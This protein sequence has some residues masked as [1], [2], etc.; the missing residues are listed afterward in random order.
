[1]KTE[2]Y[3]LRFVFHFIC[4][5]IVTYVALGGMQEL[6][7]LIRETSIP[8]ICICNDKT[9][10]KMRSLVTNTFDLTFSRPKVEQIKSAI[11][12]ICFK[13]RI[14]IP[15]DS[16]NEIITGASQDMRQILNLLSMW[17]VNNKNLSSDSIARDSKLIKK[18]MKMVRC[19]NILF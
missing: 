16:F 10:M 19:K 3:E 7:S 15:Q 2:V 11:R 14:N 17:S 12:S 6:L 8:I 1:M 5:L 13:E 4:S 9:L 18:D